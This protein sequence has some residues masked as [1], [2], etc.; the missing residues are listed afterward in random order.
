MHHV[1]AW[2]ADCHAVVCVSDGGASRLNTRGYKLQINF[3]RKRL[4]ICV[5]NIKHKF[6]PLK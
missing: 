4:R 3:I 5:V 6:T 1:K 2:S